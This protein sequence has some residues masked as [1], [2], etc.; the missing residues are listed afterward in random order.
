M[1]K[2]Y[3]T[4]DKNNNLKNDPDQSIWT[5]SRDP[6]ETGW[7]T[8]SG[9]PGYGLT[10]ADAQELANAANRIADLEALYKSEMQTLSSALFVAMMMR[11]KQKIQLQNPSVDN[12]VEAKAAESIFDSIAIAMEK[13]YEQ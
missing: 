3:V 2:W 13:M 11:K 5:V 1:V 12:L 6:I 8:D 9:C 4:A 7:E 10:K